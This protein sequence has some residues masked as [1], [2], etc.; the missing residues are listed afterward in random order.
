MNEIKSANICKMMVFTI[1]CGDSISIDS[2]WLTRSHCI[3]PHIGMIGKQASKKKKMKEYY[4]RIVSIT[5]GT[6]V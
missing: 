5:L 3:F 2:L 6:N 4:A 1:R